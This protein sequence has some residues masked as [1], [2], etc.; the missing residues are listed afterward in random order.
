MKYKRNYYN[1]KKQK[2]GILSQMAIEKMKLLRIT[3]P[4]KELDRFIARNLLN[5]D[6]QIEDAKKIYSKGW[7][8]EYYSYDYTIKENLKKC[9]DLIENLNILYREDYTNLFIENTVLQ[10]GTKLERVE[11]AFLNLKNEM[12]FCQKTKEEDL[13]K[14]VSVQKLEHINI[15]IKKLYELKYMKFRYGN[16]ETS[17]LD[18]IRAELDNMHVILFEIEKK[19]DITWI[20]YVTTEEF[21]QNVDVFFNMQNFE[22]VWL[23]PNLSGTPKEY[24]EK[25]YKDMSDKTVQMQN[26]QKEMED[27][28]DNATHL[29]LSA[30][31]Q[32]QT[33][34][35]I[36][37]IKKLIVHDSKHTFYLVAWVPEAE[38]NAMIE[39]L[40]T[41]Q[42]MDYQIEEKLQN[43]GPTKLKN[44]RLIKPFE[45]LVKM[46]GVPNANE[47]DPTLF[48]AITAFIM[49]GFMFGDVG[50]GV[51]FLILGILLRFRTK[52]AG[53]ILIMRRFGI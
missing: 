46:Y 43:K 48:V 35:K 4:E 3:G 19:P 44:N 22:R 18:A 53:D 25:L 33:Y 28:A 37:K 10:I 32:L 1:N 27:L 8:L 51:V 49:F 13:Q 2:K 20:V 11:Q 30:Y 40:D 12:D 38:L 26:L 23:D 16:I 29:L 6:I 17:K 14:I 39:K 15:D 47:I 21:V 34:D 41:C 52:D 36:N 31:R 7:K 45:L 50:H 5:S 24:I 42:N 9:K